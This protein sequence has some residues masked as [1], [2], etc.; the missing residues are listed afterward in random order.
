VAADSAGQGERAQAARD[1]AAALEPKLSKLRIVVTPEAAVPGLQVQ[2]NG[3]IVGGLLWGTDVPVDPGRFVVSASALF[4]EPWST[5]VAVG[6]QGE[7]VVVRVP[8]LAKVTDMNQPTTTQRAPSGEADASEERSVVPALAL[9]GVALAGVG[10]GIGFAARSSAQSSET[11]DLRNIIMTENGSCSPKGSVHSKCAELESAATGAPLT[12]GLSIGS[13]IVGGLAA[14]GAVVYLL[15]PTAQAKT[16]ERTSL[17][18]FPGTN[19]SSG[20][21]IAV[22]SF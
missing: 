3:I 21:I 7:V 17:W 2:R 13:F 19:G 18:L 8:A 10:A 11:E 1:R 12:R 6:K 22:G 20:S 14:A 16:A 4:R 15:W 5:T 9:G